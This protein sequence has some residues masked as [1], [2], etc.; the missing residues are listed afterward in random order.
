M[1]KW[2]PLIRSVVKRHTI[3]EAKDIAKLFASWPG[4]KL[5]EKSQDLTISF[6]ITNS[7][8]LGQLLKAQLPLSSTKEPSLCCMTIGDMFNIQTNSMSL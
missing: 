8:P 6:S 5:R 7:V 3:V 2:S 1:I 4:A